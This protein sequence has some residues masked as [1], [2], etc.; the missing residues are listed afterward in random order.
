MSFRC[1]SKSCKHQEIHIFDCTLESFNNITQMHCKLV[2][3][4]RLW[5]NLTITENVKKSHQMFVW[6]LKIILKSC[7]AVLHFQTNFIVICS[8][9]ACVNSST[10]AAIHLSRSHVKQTVSFKFC[11]FYLHQVLELF[12]VITHCFTIA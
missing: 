4:S 2:V 3:W 8:L 6:I 12:L 1:C 7:K 10:C 9:I 5:L 11:W